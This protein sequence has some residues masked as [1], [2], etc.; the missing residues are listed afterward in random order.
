[1]AV[2]IIHFE[3]H[4][5]DIGRARQFYGDLFGW[6][7]EQANVGDTEYWL[8]RT[9]RTPARD[10][11]KVGIDGGLLAKGGKDGGEGASPNAFVC[12]VQVENIDETLE[13]AVAAGAVPQMS[14]DHMPGVGWLC[15]LKDPEGNIFGILQPEKK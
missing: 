7:F 4:A 1:M 13:L 3:I 15:Y 10:G 2:G 8:I 5:N 9:G 11:E 12:T 6:S 14:K